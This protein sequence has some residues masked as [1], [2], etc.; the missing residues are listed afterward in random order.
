MK[1][2]ITAT[3]AGAFAIATSF[4]AEIGKPAPEFASKTA[5]G[6][7]VTLSD[8]KGKVVVLEWIN[9]DCPFVQKHYSGKNMQNLQAD[10]TAKEV[11]WLTV[12][13]SA[14][15]KQGY[16]EGSK[17]AEKVSSEGSK[18]TAVIMDTSG[19]I[20][21]AYDAKVTPH[22]MIIDKEGNLMY[23]GAMDSVKSTDAAD[24]A[25]ADKLF[26]NA[27]DAV[28]EGKEVQN[29]MNEPYGCSVKY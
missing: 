21:K 26:A 4:A 13:S 25:T 20:G 12:N 27:L 11:V 23:S 15:D 18:A 16:M 24:V 28:L 10:Y 29:A 5:K 3:I 14:K 2:F 6:E 7:E 17:M 19:E 1:S 8:Y 22:M 9:F